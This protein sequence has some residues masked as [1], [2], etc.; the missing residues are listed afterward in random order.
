MSELLDWML[1]HLLESSWT[2][3]PEWNRI[4]TN[5]IKTQNINSYRPRQTKQCPV[6]ESMGLA[7][8]KCESRW[9]IDSRNT[10]S[11]ERGSSWPEFSVRQEVVNL[12]INVFIQPA[13][14]S[15]WWKHTYCK[16][17]SSI[18]WSGIA[19]PN[20]AKMLVRDLWSA[21]TDFLHFA[22]CGFYHWFEKR[23]LLLKITFW[24]ELDKVE[25][26][27]TQA[28]GPATVHRSCHTS[29]AGQGHLLAMILWVVIIMILFYHCYGT[30]HQSAHSVFRMPSSFITIGW[31]VAAALLPWLFGKDPRSHHK[32]ATGRVRAGN[33]LLPVLCHCQLGQDI[34]TSIHNPKHW[35]RQLRPAYFNEQW[36]ITTMIMNNDKKARMQRMRYNYIQWK[37]YFHLWLTT[38]TMTTTL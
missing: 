21:R 20:L 2:Q 6:C 12:K 30:F 10:T 29:H 14:Q 25:I 38:V 11:L 35:N 36:T 26:P 17:S 13:E 19:V 5:Q 3:V 24:W 9:P 32:G 27:N 31:R 15:D 37:F 34:P 8:S 4:C 16:C 7:S 18:R 23:N 1:C 33:Q 22:C 28:R